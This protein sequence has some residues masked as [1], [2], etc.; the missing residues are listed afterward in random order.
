MDCT[1]SLSHFHKLIRKDFHNSSFCSIENLSILNWSGL[2]HAVDVM[3]ARHAANQSLP[4]NTTMNHSSLAQRAI[5]APKKFP[6]LHES[7][8]FAPRMTEHLP[9][10][11]Q[12]VRF[13][14][15][16]NTEISTAIAK[17]GALSST[18]WHFR[19]ASLSCFVSRHTSCAPR[20]VR[21]PRLPRRPA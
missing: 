8:I 19:S 2:A 21:L 5:L 17:L 15:T 12:H 13:C 9:L 14:I 10:I 20:V 11:I 7:Q 16:E 3:E 6:A 4:Y 18:F 1:Y